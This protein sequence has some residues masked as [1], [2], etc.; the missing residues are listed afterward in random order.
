MR[1]LTFNWHEAYLCLLAG[2]GHQWDIV[3]RLKG[4]SRS[5]F[6]AI[7]PVPGNARIVSEATARQRLR[8]RT[9][10]VV[11]CHNL[12]DA[13]LIE[14]YAVGKVLVFHNKLSTEL[15]LGGRLDQRDAVLA[16]YRR[17]LAAEPQFQPVFISEGKRADWGL[18]GEVI[19]PGIPPA[20]YG[21]YEGHERR[22]L[23]VGNLMKARDLMLGY[24]IQREV[25]R[26]IPSTLLGL[27]EPEPGGRFSESWDDLRACFRSHRLFLNTTVEP[28][29]DGYNLAMLEAMATGMPVVSLSN[30]TSPIVDGVNGY[31]SA[32]RG[33]LR[34]K[35]AALMA[36]RDLAARLGRAAR[37]TVASE[38][39]IERFAASWNGLLER[40]AAEQPPKRVARFRTRQADEPSVLSG[41]PRKRVML[42]YVS[43]PAT[44]ARFLEASLRKRHEVVTVGPAID[45]QLIEAWNLQR[46][47]EPVRPHD[48][49]SPA[50]VDISRVAE[51]LASR[52]QPDLFLWIESVPG[53]RPRRIPRLDCPTACYLIDTHLNMPLHLEWAPKF[54]WVFLAQREYVR[55][56]ELGGCAHVAWLPLGC[57][58]SIHRVGDVPKRHDIGFVGSVT[59]DNP[60]RR[61]LLDRLSRRFG[62]HVERSFL[63]EMATTF[64]ASRMVFNNA[65]RNDLNMRV[66]EVLCSGSLLLTDRIPG[67]GLEEMFLDR[68]HVAYYEDDS[69]EETA[70]YYLAHDEEREAIAAKGQAEALRWHTY[71]RRAEALMRTVF[72]SGQEAFDAVRLASPSDEAVASAEGARQGGMDELARQLT[73][74]ARN[75]RELTAYDSWRLLGTPLGAWGR[76]GVS[77]LTTQ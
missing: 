60:R 22:V 65:I 46:L 70:A 58:P 21:G 54:D 33:E 48:I 51:R 26:D 13:Q 39:P 9:Y 36:D 35:V 34:S 74:S 68:E 32:D 27:N 30:S 76:A 49:P 15:A 43:Y 63:R 69:I 3:E 25:L 11:V 77:T 2:I 19:R 6:Y 57:D 37:D 45:Q 52:W 10:D 5:W 53:H 23:R 55:T 24:S 56:F 1:V 41:S 61:A 17:L 20:D 38:F 64:A 29:E 67:S 59:A 16:G 40:A 66:F 72:E 18:A 44:T 7:R 75:D 42:A 73:D 71:D 28:Y 62:V 47:G 31:A 12:A 8:D 4:G 50:D 14:E